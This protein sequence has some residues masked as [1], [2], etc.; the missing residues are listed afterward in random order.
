VPSAEDDDTLRCP[1]DGMTLDPRI[2]EGNVEVDSC[3][4]CRGMW[5]DA[6]ELEKIQ[7][8]SERDYSGELHRDADSAAA[9]VEVA[10]QLG[11]GP[12]PCPVCGNEMATR[13]YGYC[14]QVVIDTC[15][16]GC[17]VW[18]DAGEIQALE[19]F[20]ERAQQSAGDVIP[21]RWRL[22]ASVRSVFGR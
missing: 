4:S 22:W 20:F 21:L 2:Y 16:A 7:K 3:A 5:L 8:S 10:E 18:L 15:P 14:S 19:K 17:G 9:G 12:V 1:R 11:Q 6:G 13:E